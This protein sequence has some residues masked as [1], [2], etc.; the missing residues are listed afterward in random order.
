MGRERRLGA[1][2]VWVVCTTVAVL[3]MA[4]GSRATPPTPAPDLDAA[5][6]PETAGP[7]VCTPLGCV[8]APSSPWTYGASFAAAVLAAGWLGRRRRSRTDAAAE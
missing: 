5:A 4:S 3:L 8:G 1:R 6:L 7:R 2:V